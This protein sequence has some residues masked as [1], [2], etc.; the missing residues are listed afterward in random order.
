MMID[1]PSSRGEG[2][3]VLPP[4][5]SSRDFPLRPKADQLHR[6]YPDCYKS[7]MDANLA[8]HV[9]RQRMSDKKEFIAKI[10][11]EIERLESNLSPEGT[12]HIRLHKMNVKLLDAL[13]KMEGFADDITRVAYEGNRAPRT[14]L[15]HFI[16]QLKDFA[17]RWRAFKLELQ[18]ELLEVGEDNS[19]KE[20]NG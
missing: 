1:Q 16:E 10:R 9:L 20:L 7:L 19:R 4:F 6:L 11:L 8:R 18:Q 14:G 3:D 5:R 17:R 15:R 13:K 2:P 12:A